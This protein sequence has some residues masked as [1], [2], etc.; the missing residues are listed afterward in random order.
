MKGVPDGTRSQIVRGAASAQQDE[1]MLSDWIFDRSRPDV[2]PV[3]T[4]PD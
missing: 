2:V 3:A 4:S 1:V